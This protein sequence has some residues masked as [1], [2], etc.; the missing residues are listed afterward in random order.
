MKV[1]RLED[2]GKSVQGY[3]YVFEDLTEIKAMQDKISHAEQLAAVGR[4]SAG[5]AHEIRNP[6]ASLR[7]YAS[8]GG[9]RR[10]RYHKIWMKTK[11]IYYA[12]V[13]KVK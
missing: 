2:K 13:S 9:W 6:L 10:A 8:F 1:S 11:L 4:F 3:I 12:G 5:L 7:C